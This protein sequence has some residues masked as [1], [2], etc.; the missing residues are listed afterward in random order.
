M[1]N[2]EYSIQLNDRDWAD[3]FYEAEE[4]HLEEASLATA[5]DQVL[6]DTD[7][8]ENPQEEGH[9]RSSRQVKISLC[10]AELGPVSSIWDPTV[11]NI[12]GISDHQHALRE[13]QVPCDQD[14]LSG[15]EDE[16][17][18]IGS[19]S[20]YLCER[21][22]T[23]QHQTAST[24][25]ESH[26]VSSCASRTTRTSR[27][28]MQHLS[29]K[30]IVSCENLSNGQEGKGWTPEDNGAD[31]LICPLPNAF[32]G[33][34]KS[35]IPS[36]IGSP[37]EQNGGAAISSTGPGSEAAPGQSI[38]YPVLMV[39]LPGAKSARARLPTLPPQ[40][41]E[42]SSQES[43]VHSTSTK[44]AQLGENRGESANFTSPGISHNSHQ[45]AEGSLAVKPPILE[46]PGN[47][48]VESSRGEEVKI[49]TC[50]SLNGQSGIDN[51]HSKTVQFPRQ[52]NLTEEISLEEVANGPLPN[53]NG[54]KHSGPLS[55]MPG[56]R[57]SIKTEGLVED[58]EGI[59]R[60]VGKT[61][62][63]H[64]TV[65]SLSTCIGD[66]L[67][68]VNPDWEEQEGPD[69]D[70]FVPEMFTPS[71]DNFT[72]TFPETY[73]FFFC[74]SHEQGESGSQDIKGNINSEPGTLL[75]TDSEGTMS[76]PEIYE[77]FFCEGQKDDGM[78]ERAPLVR[79][80]SSRTRPPSAPAG[81]HSTEEQPTSISFPEAYEYFFDDSS[82]PIRR[83]RGLFGMSSFRATGL[84]AAWRSLLPR[85]T[86]MQVKTSSSIITT[87][88]KAGGQRQLFPLLMN[89]HLTKEES[90]EQTEASRKAI[91]IRGVHPRQLIIG[92]GDMCL[93]FLAFATWA[94]KTTDLQAPD[95]WKTALL[96]NLGAVTAIRYLRRRAGGEGGRLYRHH[97]EEPSL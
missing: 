16:E 44:G 33:I 64:P 31:P 11:H 47:E 35:R 21:D 95:A 55:S 6:S 72:M 78:A 94:V 87:E 90:Q 5:D 43:P 39:E 63:G 92:Q 61:I 30:H 91:A 83:H 4:C 41:C 68:M 73:D 13:L 51:C 37:I 52:D 75:V 89:P 22:T 7:P 8:E 66:P 29:R 82:G 93:V 74:D 1:D 96:A 86:N 71:E 2:F 49:P 50:N 18:E 85:R 45:N 58:L 97:R 38:L 84:P 34:Q 48:E 81:D 54:I 62:S 24:M 56:N 53:C 14:V 32:S 19:V 27:K 60:S 26:M 79:G 15:S 46:N 12:L 20:R 76:S 3:F 25:L 77:Y 59:H 69:S 28:V 36:V 42:D 40:A 65:P 17:G 70:S 10:S 80:W 67:C 88:M 9:T 57:I 23:W